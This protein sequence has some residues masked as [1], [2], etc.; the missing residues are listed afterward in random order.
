MLYKYLIEDL[1]QICPGGLLSC[2]IQL[3]QHP[4]QLCSSVNSSKMEKYIYIHVF[5]LLELQ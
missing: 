2:T 5:T 4:C 1:F 3:D